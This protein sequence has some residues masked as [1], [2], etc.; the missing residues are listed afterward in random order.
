MRHVEVLL[1]CLQSDGLFSAL[2]KQGK[3]DVCCHSSLLRAAGAGGR[4]RGQRRARPVGGGDGDGQDLHRAAPSRS[5]RCVSITV[6]LFAL[7]GQHLL[8]YFTALYRV[9]QV[10]GYAW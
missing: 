9:L 3:P 8:P 10:T 6:S 4:V 2:C 7:F 5:H 1:R